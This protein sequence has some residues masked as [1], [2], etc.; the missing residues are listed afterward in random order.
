MAK[1]AKKTKTSGSPAAV[2]ARKVKRLE[3]KKRRLMNE[4][5][6]AR[7]RIADLEA[8]LDDA[9]DPRLSVETDEDRAADEADEAYHPLDDDKLASGTD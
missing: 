1:K 6:A 9:L 2:L 7:E 5:D 3:Q 8:Q 4:V